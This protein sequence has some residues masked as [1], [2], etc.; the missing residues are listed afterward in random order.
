[1]KYHWSPRLWRGKGLALIAAASLAASAHAG[2][3]PTK[4]PPTGEKSLPDILT[5]VYGGSFTS[6]GNDFVNGSGV[7]AVRIDDSNDQTWNSG[8]YSLRTL[9]SFSS[10]K[11]SESFGFVDG[12][13]GG[14]FQNLFDV[15]G[16][17]L[18]ATGSASHDFSSSFRLALDTTALSSGGD[19][20]T[21]KDSDNADSR[22]HALTYRIDGLG[23]NLTTYVT[24]W[25][26]LNI[27]LVSPNRS[28]HDFNDLAVELVRSGGATASAV[29]LPPAVWSGGMVLAGT[30]FMMRKR[31]QI[32]TA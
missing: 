15:S 31:A 25:E 30:L 12:T 23:N 7:T 28:A 5:N 11:V 9:A 29:P 3:T 27:D 24:F 22:D 17:K 10:D 19:V 2:L 8:S 13:S 6:Q 4:A 21:S 26:D 18:G 16:K 14:S 32:Q 1:M 20:Y